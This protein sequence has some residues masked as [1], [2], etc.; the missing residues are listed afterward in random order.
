MKWEREKRGQL[1]A[2]VLVGVALKKKEDGKKINTIVP[3]RQCDKVQKLAP[4]QKKKEVSQLSHVGWG[5]KKLTTRKRQLG[6]HQKELEQV[7]GTKI[8]GCCDDSDGRRRKLAPGS[9]LIN[10]RAVPGMR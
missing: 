6:S 5:E 4:R 1:S 3:V 8:G 7:L 9:R 10:K 2:G